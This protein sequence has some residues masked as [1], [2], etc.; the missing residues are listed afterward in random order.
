MGDT[1]TTYTIE[2]LAE[3]A[4]MTPRNV[5]AYRTK[6]LLPAPVRRGRTAVYH[7]EHLRRLV[8]VQRLRDAGVP[9]GMIAQA[10]RRGEDLG[11]E[12]ELWRLTLGSAAPALRGGLPDAAAAE[13]P[14]TVDLRETPDWQPLDTELVDRLEGEGGLLRQLGVLG[15]LSGSGRL[16]YASSELSQA[17]QALAGQ[18]V[19]PSTALTVALHAAQATQRLATTVSAV[20]GDAEDGARS[21]A[22]RELLVGLSA[23]VVRDTLARELAPTP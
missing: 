5:R 8:D 18:G 14:R 7:D 13:A 3:R 23:G 11:R 4:G 19:A 21:P 10:V 22:A 2:E 6:G 9:L 12:G 16:L 1:G 20:L 15:V 17:L